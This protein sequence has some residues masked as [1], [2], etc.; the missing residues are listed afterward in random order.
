MQTSIAPSKVASPD[1]GS[2]IA[3]KLSSKIDMQCCY[4]DKYFH[5]HKALS[6]HLTHAN[7]PVSAVK[8]E[9]APLP[10][11]K[12]KPVQ[13]TPKAAD[14]WSACASAFAWRQAVA[15]NLKRDANSLNWSMLRSVAI[16]LLFRADGIVVMHEGLPIPCVALFAL[17]TKAGQPVKERL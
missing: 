15:A 6:H 17:G 7:V 16:K 4:D 12:R 1:F 14:Q 11:R 2:T 5:F 3:L 13:K 8:M 10:L 9:S